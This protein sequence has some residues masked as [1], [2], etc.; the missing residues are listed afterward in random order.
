MQFVVNRISQATEKTFDGRAYL[1][2]PV[3][4]LVAGVLNDALVTAEEAGKY[5]A[6]WNG[7]P[8]TLSHPQRNG[9]YVSAGTP[10]INATEAPGQVWNAA[11]ADGKL[12]AEIWIDIAKATAIGG[13]AL[14][15]MDRLRKNQPVEVSTGYFADHEQSNGMHNGKAYSMIAR[16][17]RP[18]HLALLPGGVGACSWQDGCGT[19]RVNAEQKPCGCSTQK[20]SDV[21]RDKT[22]VN[23]QE[24]GDRYGLI[25]RKFRDNFPANSGEMSD[26]DNVAVFENYV[27]AQSWKGKGWS[28][29]AYTVNGDAVTFDAPLPVDVIYRSKADGSELV[30]VNKARQVADESFVSAVVNGLLTALGRGKQTDLAANADQEGLEDEMGEVKTKAT[31]VAAAPVAETPA[32]NTPAVNNAQADVLVNLATAIEAVNKRLDGIDAKL[33]ANANK[34]R[35]ELVAALAV[36]ERCPFDAEE[37]KA[38]STQHLHKL[39]GAYAPADY[40][41]GAGVVGNRSNDVFETLAMPAWAVAGEGK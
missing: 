12:T 28:A 7:R 13:D 25:R 17:L 30:T 33:T 36:N 35:D 20:G 31:P 39:A 11:F 34:E 1:V 8:A 15:V 3:T 27:I 6:S 40:S 18:D 2:A 16:N 26:W 4:M 5:V 19:P 21:E 41:A 37:L 29:F 23:E 9:E 22:V 38:L 24:M 14:T 10:E 32:V